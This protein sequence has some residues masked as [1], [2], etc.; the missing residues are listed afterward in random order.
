MRQNMTEYNR[1]EKQTIGTTSAVVS[2]EKENLTSER[3]SITIINTS[4]GG[5]EITLSIDEPAVSNEGIV[6]S[7]GGV[8]T[9]N[10][11]GGYLP[12][13]KAIH[14]I[15]SLAGGQISIQERLEQ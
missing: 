1:N 15:S 5:Q 10:A 11:E 8:W 14:A 6:L 9:D 4:T 2:I 12:T 13:Q 3:R 7:V